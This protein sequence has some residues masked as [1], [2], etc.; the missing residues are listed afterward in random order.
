LWAA[1][2]AARSGPTGWAWVPG[3]A[4]KT[5]ADAAIAKRHVM[6][7]GCM[8]YPPTDPEPL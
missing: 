3:S 5:I 1:I 8:V 4:G 2:K 6:R 7:K